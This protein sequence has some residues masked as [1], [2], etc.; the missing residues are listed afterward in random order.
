MT[1]RLLQSPDPAP[2]WRPMAYGDLAAVE[3]IAAQVHAGFFERREVFEDKLGLDPGGCFA[4]DLDGAVAG[5]AFSHPWRL[6]DVPALD[7]FLGALPAAP[8]CLYLHDVAL[9]E[10]ARGRG[11]SA[12]LLDLLTSRATVEALPALALVAVHGSA[13]FWRGAGFEDAPEANSTLAT[14]GP[15]ARYMIRRLR[16]S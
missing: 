4:L 8:E 5:Y 6:N 3:R 11:A 12:Q 13:P 9:S 7:G 10:S 16:Q 15:A 14:Y 2:S 1:G